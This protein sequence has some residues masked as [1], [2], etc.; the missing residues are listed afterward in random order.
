MT[1]A[2]LAVGLALASRWR[3]P[4]SPVVL[5]ML[6]AASVNAAGLPHR[7]LPGWAADAAMAVLGAWVGMRFQ[8]QGLI[9]HLALAGWAAL[10]SLGLLAASLGVG[11]A[12]HRITG[13]PVLASVLATAPGALE[14]MTAAALATGAQPGMVLSFHVMRMLASLAVGPVLASHLTANARLAP[15]GPNATSGGS[16]PAEHPPRLRG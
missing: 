7:P 16:H 4:A 1:L 12:L 9:R 3:I 8:R 11:W 13:M 10:L 15:S 5:P 2:A 14:S 6:L